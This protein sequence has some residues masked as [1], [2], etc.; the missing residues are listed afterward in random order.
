MQIRHPDALI[1][2]RA[3]AKINLFL[4]VLQR[5][6]DGFHEIETLMVPVDLSDTV[7]L[8]RSARGQLRVA[9]RWASGLRAVARSPRGGAAAGV[10]SEL[11]QGEDNLVFR[12]LARFREAS[13]VQAGIDVEIHKRIPAAAGLG[14]ASSDAAA[15]LLAANRLWALDWTR[16]RLALIAAEVG[17]DVPFFLYGS[18]AICR[19]R[20]ERVEPLRA[21]QG[22]WLVV[23]RPPAGLSTA[24]I[25]RNCEPASD[26]VALCPAADSSSLPAR[27]ATRRRSLDTL[28]EAALRGNSAAIAGGMFNRLQP[29]AERCSP[30]IARLG[31]AFERLGC[32]GHQMSGSG[33]SYFGICRHAAHAGRVAARLRAS[34]LGAVFLTTTTGIALAPK[35]NHFKEERHADHRGSRQTDGAV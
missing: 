2:I 27:L 19:G 1:E 13:G 25:Y 31:R 34:D 16:E 26:A 30:W 8:R 9:C 15:A 20:G 11:P 35:A 17:S 33:S 12:A 7:R 23:V 21:L 28:L 29:A 22:L 4:E 18:A 24:E 32:R 3:P 6:P 5:R 10:W 14:G